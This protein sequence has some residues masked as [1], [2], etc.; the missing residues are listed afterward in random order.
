MLLIARTASM[1]TVLSRLKTCVPLAEGKEFSMTDKRVETVG[2]WLEQFE[3]DA[4]HMEYRKAA[5]ALL[6]LLGPVREDLIWI[7]SYLTTMGWR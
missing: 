4:G 1:T 2:R 7:S 6:E 5:L 3:D